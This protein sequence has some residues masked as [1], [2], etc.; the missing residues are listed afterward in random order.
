MTRS[1]FL[2]PK[3]APEENKFEK[4]LTAFNNIETGHDIARNKLTLADYDAIWD[5]LTSLKINGYAETSLEGAK[6]FFERNG[7]E[8]KPKEIGW[9]VS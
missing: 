6:N 5:M 1:E 8:I 9:M 7:M 4:A 2:R 3:K